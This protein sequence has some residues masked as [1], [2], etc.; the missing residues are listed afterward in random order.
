MLTTVRR[1]SHCPS[2]LGCSVPARPDG[3]C[4]RKQAP[5][6]GRES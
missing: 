3:G 1:P 2:S 5:Q 6:Q 4:G